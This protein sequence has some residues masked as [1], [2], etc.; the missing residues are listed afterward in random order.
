MKNFLFKAWSLFVIY[1]IG[2]IKWGWLKALFNHGK[3]YDLT[4]SEL[5]VLKSLLANNHYIIVT[6]RKTHFSTYLISLASFIQSGKFGYW[7]HTLMNIEGDDINVKTG[8]GFKLIEAIG[9]KGVTISTFMEVFDCDSVCLLVPKGFTPEEWTEAVKKALGELGKPYDTVFN[10]NKDDALS[11]VELARTALKSDADD[12][13]TE[14][15]EF[16]KMIKK[17]GNLTPQMY[18]DC[19]DFQKVWEFKH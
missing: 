17:A 11:C 1:G 16:E 14:F 9:T 4:P 2:Q 19:P 13:D 7:S 6:R 15:A 8:E 5:D 10:L 18:Y 3:Y 12:Y